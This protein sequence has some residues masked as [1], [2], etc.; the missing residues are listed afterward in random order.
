MTTKRRGQNSRDTG[1]N[2]LRTYLKWFYPGLGVKRYFFLAFLGV[3]LVTIGIAVVGSWRLLGFWED[4]L[5]NLVTHTVGQGTIEV[6]LAGLAVAALGIF[7][8]YQGFIRGIN[9]ILSVLL[10]GNE[11]RVV[12]MM[13]YRRNLQRGPKIVV[14]G[15]GTGLAALLRGLKSYTSNLTA[16]VTVG[17]DGGSSGRLRRELGVQP[18]GDVRN[19]MEA[20]AEK[21][22]LISDLFSYRF[23]SGTLAGH[24]LGN[25]LIAGMT[26]RYSN[27]LYGIEHVS[28]LLDLRGRV[29]PSTL[30]QMVLTASFE[31][32]R[33]IAGETAIRSTPG[34][35]KKLQLSPSEC[36]PLP[37]VLEAIAEADLIVLGPGSL[38]TSILPNLLVKGIPEKIAQAKALCIYVCNIMTEPGETDAYTA[39]DHV[40]ALIEH[41]GQ[42][43]IDAVLAATETVPEQVLENY[44]A[45]GSVP[46]RGD[47][48]A[49]ERQNIAYFEKSFYLG[50]DVIRHN[51]KQLGRELLRLYLML[52]P[53]EEQT[54]LVA[55]FLLNQK[56]K[57]V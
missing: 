8:F 46:V 5:H 57:E 14:V 7:F 2:R 4:L 6:Q 51:P 37:E 25:L 44:R 11:A 52:K 34:H 20:L 29:Y 30:D 56:I 15:G 31:D 26:E 32:G 40:N 17:D 36:R 53:L 21:E 48:E 22:E 23:E 16:I 1:Q 10:P 19:C 47:R 12:D 39:S 3:F 18:P 42:N 55:T 35:I 38:Y 50:G 9:S 41:C 33:S 54:D 28:Q 13:Y 24:S 45:Q 49:I 27:F 43:L